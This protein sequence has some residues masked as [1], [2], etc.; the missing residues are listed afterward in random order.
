[1]SHFLRKPAANSLI[2]P[3]TDAP[4]IDSGLAGSSTSSRRS[5]LSRGV[6]AAAVPAALVA[7]SKLAGAATGTTAATGPFPSYYPGSTTSK[8]QEIQLD[9]YEHVGII[10]NL[11]TS[12]GGKTR[13]LPTFQGIQNLSATQFLTLAKTFENTGVGAYLGAVYY[14]YNPQVTIAAAEIALV[15]AYHAGFINTL[16]NVPLIPNTKAPLAMPFDLETVLSG[17]APFVVSLNDNGQFPP[18]YG[19]NPS[20]TNDLAILNFALLLEMLEAEFYFYNVPAL[21]P[22]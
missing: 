19:P 3:A 15:E 14:I 10:S 13:P 16:A 22:S 12:L 8:F 7:G 1:M 9:E 21:F 2:V 4:T 17:I 5:F 20:A 18:V 6:A 11:I